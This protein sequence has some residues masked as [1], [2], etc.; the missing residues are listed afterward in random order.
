[1]TYEVLAPPALPLRQIAL[2]APVKNTITASR[3][4]RDGR[5][6]YRWEV[7]DVPR[8]YREPD[9]PGQPASLGGPQS[10]QGAILRQNLFRILAA[11][12]MHESDVDTIGPEIT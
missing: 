10:R 4:K 12:G 7:K 2:K 8:M 6:V 3:G 5:L 9:M 1:M 11:D